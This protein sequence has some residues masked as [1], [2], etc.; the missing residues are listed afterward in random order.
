LTVVHIGLELLVSLIKKADPI[1]P[2]II[3]RSTAE[4]IEQM[5]FSSNS[6]IYI[7]NDLA[8]PV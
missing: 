6:A 5:L 3:D 1:G 2:V 7:L 4:L 8:P